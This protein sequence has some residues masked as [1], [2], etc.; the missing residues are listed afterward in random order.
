MTNVII[1]PK[2][3]AFEVEACQFSSWY[4]LFRNM[5][6]NNSSSDTDAVMDDDDDDDIS[7]SSVN[8]VDKTTTTQTTTSK[9]PQRTKRRRRNNVTIESSII[10]P[11]PND[12][13]TYLL[14]DGVRLPNCA[15]KVSSCLNDNYVARTTTMDEEEETNYD[16]YDDDDDNVNE[17]LQ[18]KEYSF[19][20]L[21]SQIQTVLNNY[22]TKSGGGGC[23]PKLNWSSPRDATWINCG[24]LKCTKPGDIYLLLKCSDFITFD[25][26]KAWDGLRCCCSENDDN[27]EDDGDTDKDDDND[28]DANGED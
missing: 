11:L 6:K 5:K 27:D 7:T 17:P 19:P 8:E 25:L 14:D 3:T 10:R 22:T 16:D 26:E 23:F 24:T 18:Q 2:P 21:T 28:N 1:P 15:M 4:T 20:E 12:F 13:I 9:I